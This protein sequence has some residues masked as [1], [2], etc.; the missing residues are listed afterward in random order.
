MTIEPLSPALQTISNEIF[1]AQ[2]YEVLSKK[3]I[4][5]ATYAYISGGS[6]QDLTLLANVNSFKKRQIFPRILQDCAQGSTQTKL[7]GHSLRS[8][9]LLAPVAY[10]KLVH[11]QGELATVQA[12]EAMDIPLIL[13]TLASQTLE[14]V[15]QQTEK[16][17]WFQLY[18]QPT[19]QET[20]LLVK[21]AEQAGYSALVVTLDATIQVPSVQ[22][23]KAGFVMPQDMVAVNVQNSTDLKK[24]VLDADDSLIFQGIMAEAPL[25]QDLQWLQSQTELPIIVKGVMHPND[26][27]RLKEMGI[28]GIVVSN[29]GGRGLDGAPASLDVLPLIRKAVGENY[30]LLFDGGIRSGQD[31]FKALALGANSVLIGRLQVYA[32]AVSGALGVAH[33]LKLLQEEL[34]VCMA[35]AGCASIEEINQQAL[36]E[37]HSS[38][39]VE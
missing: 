29:H 17:K 16:I 34:E 4:Q 13:S 28:S 7:L 10:Q 6:G 8:P 14:E 26:A 36:Y 21:R 32:L 11:P 19:T 5:P 22:A 24:R 37:S 25:W 2:D 39:T 35:M 30:P 23:K 31:I 1:C 9:I 15:A 27:V 20:L 12:A 33:L 3:F 18:F 38:F